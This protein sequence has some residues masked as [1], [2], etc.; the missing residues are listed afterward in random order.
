MR[1]EGQMTD[2]WRVRVFRTG[3]YRARFYRPQKFGY[4]KENSCVNDTNTTELQAFCT[5][6]TTRRLKLQKT[7]LVA[8]AI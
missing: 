3:Y 4:L 6:K 5:I 2:N 1:L 7:T 8:A